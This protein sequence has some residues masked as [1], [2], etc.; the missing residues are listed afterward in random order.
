MFSSS[1]NSSSFIAISLSVLYCPC[2]PWQLPCIPDVAMTLHLTK[3][4]ECYD[5]G[6]MSGAR[7][8][9]CDHK[10]NSLIPGQ[11]GLKNLSLALPLELA[12]NAVGMVVVCVCFQ[13]LVYS[14]KLLGSGMD[15]ILSR[16]SCLNCN[17]E[18]RKGNSLLA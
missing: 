12:M 1:F 2:L 18:N 15:T 11:N 9:H 5:H 10:K 13:A 4:N 16:S 7:N 17:E 6:G 3:S 8:A 14:L